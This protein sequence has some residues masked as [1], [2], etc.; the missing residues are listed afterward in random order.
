MRLHDRY[1]FREL[2]TPLAYCLGG[3][4]AF[5]IPLFFFTEMETIQD[6][7]L[8]LSDTIEYCVAGLPQFFIL[9]FPLL[10]LL[11]L[12]YALTHH[13]RHNEIT[14]LRAA[15]VSL[16]R[17]C[18]P[19][20][21]VGLVATGIYF[22]FNE[23]VVPGCSRWSDEI[24]NRYVVKQD[25]AK[26]KTEFENN[27]YQADHAHRLWL[28]NKYDAKTTIMLGPRV[29]WN[30]PDG[31]G[32]ALMASAAFYTNGVWQFTN[33]QLFVLDGSQRNWVPVSTTNEIAMP[34]FDETP[35]QILRELK[36]NDANGLLASRGVD[37][38]LAELA[39][40]MR[41]NKN[42]SDKDKPR[43]LTKFHGRIAAPWTCLVVV[44]IAIPFS[45]A[46]GRRNLFFGVA[47]S[48]FICFAFFVLQQVGL[49]MGANG[50]LPAWLA[51]WLP[52]LIFT[53]LGVFL[54]LRIR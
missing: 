5:W 48:I 54:T 30:L 26:N 25:N 52:N 3:F 18:A 16:W 9:T 17:L 15:G 28:F 4:T 46:P 51:A 42:I 35:K 27:G 53:A 41:Q 10:L 40:Y 8:H 1:I 39:S 33:V 11:S 37:I 14:A 21:V 7:K 34:E 6:R 20:F 12:L 45:A 23:L 49:G 36:F 32:H 22:A 19:Y 43:L 47:G 24:L 13:A 50:Y 2:L 44:F 31:S 38:P 29:S